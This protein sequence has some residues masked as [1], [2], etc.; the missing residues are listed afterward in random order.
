MNNTPISRHWFRRFSSSGWLSVYLTVIAAPPVYYLLH[1]K[2]GIDWF[3][4]AIL[5]AV[6]SVSVGHILFVPLFLLTL[7]VLRPTLYCAVCP[8][9]GEQAIALGMCISEPTSDPA[10]YRRYQLAE[11][12]RCHRH[13]HRLGDGS[14]H[15]QHEGAEPNDAGNSR[16]A[17]Q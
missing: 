16:H 14:Y 3:Y 10:L 5:G 8:V 11:C 2:W 7:H 9:C 15:E 12:R 1:F 17:S 13:F 6:L 4:T